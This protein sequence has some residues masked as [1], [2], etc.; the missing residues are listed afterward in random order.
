MINSNSLYINNYYKKFDN[1][2]LND[3]RRKKSYLYFYT[4]YFSLN[5]NKW[6]VKSLTFLQN[7]IY[8]QRF[9][10]NKSFN[11]NSK[12]KGSNKTELVLINDSMYCSTVGLKI[13]LRL[14][15]ISNIPYSSYIF[16]EIIGH[17]L[18]DG[19]LTMTWS[20]INPFFVFTQGFIR[21]I[22]TWSV[23]NRISF[24]CKA[25]PR[26]GRSNRKGN[27]YYNIQVITRSYPFLKELYD[28]F[29]IND[30]NR[31][32]KVIPI[33]MFYWLNPIV[34]AYWAMDDGGRTSSGSGFYLHTKGFDF[35][36]VY[37]LVGILNY[38]FGIFSTV[39]N[40]ENRPVIY[41]TSK[42][43][44]LFVEMIRP[45]FHESLLYKLK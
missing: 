3:L 7:N 20:S 32:I 5:Q 16:S 42:S 41:I 24:L 8:N 14:R 25:M 15:I 23:F 4:L 35:K 40:H 37:Y 39:Q 43:K 9:I 28:V 34:M 45:Y 27:I 17:L 11:N 21:F 22:Y 12:E 13:S 18:G 38:K 10:N 29:Y 30:G 1:Y 36:S 31:I 26:L 19:S 44:N 6:K 2:V 33:D